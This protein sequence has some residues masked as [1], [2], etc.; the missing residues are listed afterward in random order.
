MDSVKLKQG[1]DSYREIAEAQRAR[2][3]ERFGK[4]VQSQAQVMRTFI[5]ILETTELT[6]SMKGVMMTVAMT[7]SVG[8]AL[9]LAQV[10]DSKIT[11]E[12]FMREIQ[13]AIDAQ[14]RLSKTL[15]GTM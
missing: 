1:A 3:G 2:L 6:E 8:M 4:I 11:D 15:G 13:H 7:P 14:G 10:Y 12:I 9:E 5:L